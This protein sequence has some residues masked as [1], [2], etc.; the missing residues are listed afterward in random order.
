MTKTPLITPWSYLQPEKK[1]LAHGLRDAERK[2][3]DVPEE[4]SADAGEAGEEKYIRFSSQ[5]SHTF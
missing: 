5:A 1:G 4:D 2:M 3:V